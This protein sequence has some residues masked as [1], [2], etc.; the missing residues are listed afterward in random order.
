MAARLYLATGDGVTIAEQ[1]ND[2]WTVQSHTLAGR[3][4]TS[5]VAYEQAILVGT[6]DGVQKSIDGGQT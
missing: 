4:A 3:N 2:S 1:H 5:I 6:T